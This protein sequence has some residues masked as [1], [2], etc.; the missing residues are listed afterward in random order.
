VAAS[1]DTIPHDLLLRAVRKH[2]DCAWAL[3]YIERWLTAPVQ[4]EDGALEPRERGTPQGSV[5]SPL[6]ANL[7][8]HYVFDR[9]M[10]KH[11]P[12]IPFERYADDA[13]C[14]CSSER[15]AQK[16]QAELEQRFAECGLTLHPGKTQIVYCKDNLR[17]GC[18]SN[19]KFDFLGYT[20]RP[21]LAMNR[22]GKT[23]VNFTPGISN[24]AAQAI[25]QTMRDWQLDCRIDKRIDDLAKMFNP[26]IRGWIN[27]YGRYHK[28]ALSRALMHLDLRL[29]RWAMSKY[30]RL[31]GHG[32]RARHWVQDVRRREPVLFAH[33]RL[34]YRATAG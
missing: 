28:S 20:F 34:L 16:L 31:R 14:H 30:R 27:Y 33:W 1:F 10:A 6:L 25:R 29:A 15:Q 12:E 24:R 8:L 9:W 3:L 23:F 18:H 4:L 22:W 19:Q 13:V 17:R 11:H 32:R 5:I 21:R 26:I 2:T 7:F